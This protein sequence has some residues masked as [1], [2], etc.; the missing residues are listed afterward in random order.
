MQKTASKALKSLFVCGA[1]MA[2]AMALA[3]PTPKDISTAVEQGQLQQAETMLRE[4]IAAKPQSAKAH[5]ELGQVLLRENR[6]SQA[7]SE[8]LAAKAMD[9]SLKFASSTQQ[10]ND[11]LE[12]TQ[13]THRPTTPAL[14]AAP[15]TPAPQGSGFSLTYAWIGIAA[16][17]L[18]ALLVRLFNRPATPSPVYQAGPSSVPDTTFG[19]AAPYPAG[20]PGGY[21]GN[22]SG[23]YPAA[24]P[25]GGSTMTGAV[26]GG[27]AGVAAG[28]A[29]SKALEG[30]HRA[31]PQAANNTQS[32]TW[33]DS[34]GLVSMDS[35]SAPAFDAGSGGDDW[36]GDDT[37]SSDDDNW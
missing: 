35:P 2:S 17:G 8:L 1:F 6:M 4:V 22:Y 33:G 32:P 5:Y 12:K 29:L 14:T 7:Q 21:S 9:P 34:Q 37:G 25:S 19:R 15:A 23:G 24:A 31:A 27:L 16:L 28:Y 36:G 20:Q 13:P 18:I 26:V 10:F 11:V 3:L 30:E